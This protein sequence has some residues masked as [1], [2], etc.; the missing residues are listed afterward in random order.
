MKMISLHYHYTLIVI[1]NLM[2]N[3]EGDITYI[4]WSSAV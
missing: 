3:G 4:K 2:L 1:N